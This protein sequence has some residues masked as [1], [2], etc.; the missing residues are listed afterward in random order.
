LWQGPAPRRAYTDNVHPYNWHWFWH[1]GTGETLNNGTHEVDVCRWALEVDFPNS[2]SAD[3]GRYHY[4][5]DWEFY[6]TLI[7]NFDY[8]DKMIS[9]EGKSCNGVPFYGRGRGSLIVGTEGS[10]IIDRDGYVIMDKGGKTIEEY[11]SGQQNVS[12]GTV[13]GGEMTDVHFGN[14][15]RA[16][17]SG[18]TLHAPIDE[19]YKSVQILLLSNI[20]WKTGETL[21]LDPSNGHMLNKKYMKNYWGREYEKGWELKV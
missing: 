16:I 19:A 18:E 20:A 7:T 8:G 17:R 2:I 13:G 9:W 1:W 12:M 6:D 4:K 5:D 11:K 15:I 21:Q 10:V 3:G 14:L